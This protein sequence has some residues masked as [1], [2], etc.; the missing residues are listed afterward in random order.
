M[1]LIYSQDIKK[2]FNHLHKDINDLL[3]VIIVLVKDVRGGESFFLN[4]MNMND[5]RKIAHVLKYS[6]GRCVVGALDKILHDGY[7]CTGT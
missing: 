2:N 6:H 1:E 3:S 7:I 4:G 5:I